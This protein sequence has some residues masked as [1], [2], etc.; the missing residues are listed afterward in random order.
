MLIKVLYTDNKYDMVKDFVLDELILSDKII[1]FYRSNR[2]V[3]VGDGP[4]RG[5][6]GFYRGPERRHSQSELFH[7][8]EL[9]N[10]PIF[11]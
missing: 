2:W 3:T 7:K 1:K 10:P 11:A 4:I 6:G 9:I 5:M 8:K